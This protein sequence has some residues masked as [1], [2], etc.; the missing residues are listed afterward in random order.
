MSGKREMGKRRCAKMRGFILKF[1]LSRQSIMLSFK[2]LKNEIFPVF[3]KKI[4]KGSSAQ[5]K[6][7]TFLRGEN[8]ECP[9]C[10]RRVIR[11]LSG[12]IIIHPHPF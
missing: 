9:R 10:G 2:A 1:I 5:R 12:I 8:K 3:R 6:S 4:E 11:M 7:S